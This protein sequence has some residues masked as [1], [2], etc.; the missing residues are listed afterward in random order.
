MGAETSFIRKTGLVYWRMAILRCAIYAVMVGTTEFISLTEDIFQSDWKAM[1]AFEICRIFFKVTIVVLGTV[2]A[3]LDTTMGKLRQ[4]HPEN[5][6]NPQN[7]T[8]G[9][10]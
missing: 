7:Q 10:R 5:P 6:D 8:E 9:Q 1:G 3:F 2:L 4:D